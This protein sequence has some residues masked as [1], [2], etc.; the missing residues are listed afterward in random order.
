MIA[1]EN[2]TR[3]NQSAPVFVPTSEW[4]WQPEVKNIDSINTNFIEASGGNSTSRNTFSSQMDH[5][6]NY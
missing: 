5:G 6:E 4:N 2:M 1:F 3:V